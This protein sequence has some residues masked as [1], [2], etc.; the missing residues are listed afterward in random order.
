[1]KAGTS[2]GEAEVDLELTRE[3]ILL[4]GIW[5]LFMGAFVLFLRGSTQGTQVA[6][7]LWRGRTLPPLESI[8]GSP[9]EKR[10]YQ[11]RRLPLAVSYS[12]LERPE[13]R[14][15]TLSKDI[16]KGGVCI[17]LPTS[18]ARG[19]RLSLSIQLPRGGTPFSVRGEVVWQTAL[20]ATTKS[21]YD[22]GI[23]FVQLNPSHILTIARFL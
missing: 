15:T 3:F 21:R 13:Y 11:R 4:A 9:L 20:L 17:P 5:A 6:E 19:S 23:Q 14:G 8:A 2:K 18:L 16:S 7:T 10:L 12:L 1:M 22:T